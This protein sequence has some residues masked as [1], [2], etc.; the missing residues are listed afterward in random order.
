MAYQLPNKNP[1]DVTRRVAIGVSV[2]F[3]S[4][5]V[6]NQTYTTN[7]QIKSNIINYVLTNPGERVFNPNFGLDLQAKLFE[8]ITPVYTSNIENQ[9]LTDIQAY[10]PSV[11]IKELKITPDYDNNSIT[12]FINYS[13]LGDNNTINLE[14]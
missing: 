13:Y 6:F 11:V 10:F 14:L 12:I 2:P 5:S 1:L 4:P 8:N 3:N 9:L 7:D